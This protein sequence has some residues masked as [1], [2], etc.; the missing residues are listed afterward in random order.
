MFKNIIIAPFVFSIV[1]LCFK[2]NRR[3]C[4]FCPLVTYV[5]VCVSVLHSGT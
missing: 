2:L 1:I 4:Y 5:S 3:I